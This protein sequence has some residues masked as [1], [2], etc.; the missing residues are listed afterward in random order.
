MLQICNNCF[1]F[2]MFPKSKLYY[3]YILFF[4][5]IVSDRTTATCCLGIRK[6]CEFLS[7]VNEFGDSE[8]ESLVII[9]GKCDNSSSTSK[10]DVL[11]S[12]IFQ[13]VP[14]LKNVY[15]V[16]SL[17]EF[18]HSKPF[19]PLKNNLVYLSII[20][21]KISEIPNEIFVDLIRLKKLVLRDSEISSI[22]EGAFKN[23]KRLEVLLLSGNKLKEVLSNTLS[24]VTV[25]TLDLSF[26]KI[27]KI[28]KHAFSD[29][30][31]LLNLKKN[32]LTNL[33]DETFSNLNSLEML[34]LSKNKLQYLNKNTFKGLSNLSKLDLSKNQI[35]TIEPDTFS[36]LNEIMFLY[37]KYNRLSTL[38]ADI[39]LKD[40]INLTDLELEQNNLTALSESLFQRMPNLEEISIGGNPWDCENHKVLLEIILSK[41]ISISDDNRISKCD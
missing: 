18:N 13:K 37:L 34:I 9:P 7:D 26:N 17:V 40:M 6:V 38:S 10:T 33:Q 4:L 11:S 21:N 20:R 15:I 3:F 28:D 19:E 31:I 29:N 41:D 8:W 39:F 16:D 24:N 22:S 2:N 32:E 14:N 12:D 30:L 5:V 27:S 1:K 36:N 25:K 35:E 23:L